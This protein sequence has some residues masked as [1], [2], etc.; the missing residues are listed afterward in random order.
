MARRLTKPAAKRSRE[1]SPERIPG[2]VP[3]WPMS[4]AQAEQIIAALE[5]IESL[6][7]RVL[8]VGR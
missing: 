5:R 4:S 3:D 1:R 2:R 6:L 8:G 7:R